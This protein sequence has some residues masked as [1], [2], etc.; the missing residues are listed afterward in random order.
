MDDLA[1][2]RERMVLEQLER[3]GIRDAR[4]LAAMRMVERD[5][6]IPQEYAAQAYDDEPLPIGAEQTISQPYMVAL[7]CEVAQLTGDER[8]LEVGTGSGYAAAVLARLAA[9]VYSMEC[10]PQFYERARGLRLSR[11]QTSI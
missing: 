9:T 1:R 7:M 11:S 5:R 6:F 4:V 8:V 10:L 2:A 3:R